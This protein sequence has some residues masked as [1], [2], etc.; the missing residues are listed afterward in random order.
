[1]AYFHFLIDASVS[2]R[3]FQ[4]T[5]VYTRLMDQLDHLV[6]LNQNKFNPDQVGLTI[7]DDHLRLRILTIPITELRN[8]MQQTLDYKPGSAIIDAMAMTSSWLQEQ[9]DQADYTKHVLVFSDFEENASRFYT[10][11]TLG[12]LIKNYREEHGFEFYAFGLKRS[13]E[14]LFIKMNFSLE[15][16]I[17]LEE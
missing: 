16:L 12:E 4:N 6:E 1:M 11:E 10:V 13:Q 7:F 2:H 8:K 14:S 17:F 9:L 5:P 3:V 15:N